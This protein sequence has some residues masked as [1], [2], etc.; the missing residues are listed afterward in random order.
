MSCHD[1]VSCRA[2]TAEKR[3]RFQVNECE[4]GVGCSGTGMDLSSGNSVRLC[5][6]H[7]ARCQYLFS[8]CSLQKDSD[9]LE[10][11]RTGGICSEVVNWHTFRIIKFSVR[12]RV[13]KFPA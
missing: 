6:C 3:D 9:L 8:C 2:V 11:R 7:P 10:I 4:F 13:Q 12:S 1:S 5:Q